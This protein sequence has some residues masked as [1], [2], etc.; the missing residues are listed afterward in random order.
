[1][2]IKTGGDVIKICAGDMTIDKLL[3]EIQRN[4]DLA[5]N[6]EKNNRFSSK[7]IIYDLKKERGIK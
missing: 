4:I 3:K 7:K 5:R 2:L 1:M 6:L